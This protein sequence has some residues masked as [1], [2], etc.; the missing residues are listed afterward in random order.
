MEGLAYEIYEIILL[1]NLSILIK[2]GSVTELHQMLKRSQ[3]EDKEGGCGQRLRPCQHFQ[4]AQKN[5]PK[6]VY[7]KLEVCDF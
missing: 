6:H 2:K 1:T 5:A 3:K 7:L 4:I